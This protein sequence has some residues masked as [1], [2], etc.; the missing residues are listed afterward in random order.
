MQKWEYL[1]VNLAHEHWGDSHGQQGTLSQRKLPSQ[2]DWWDPS[3]LLSSL[4]EQGWELVDTSPGGNN[5][6]PRLYFK[7]SKA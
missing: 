6:R 3:P 2:G 1:V 5:D 4:G 7:R